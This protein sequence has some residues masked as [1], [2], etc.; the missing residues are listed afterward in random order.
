MFSNTTV[1]E[2]CKCY[3]DECEMRTCNTLLCVEVMSHE[4][5]RDKAAFLIFPLKFF[6][7]IQVVIWHYLHLKC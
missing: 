4:D 5:T 3:V 1:D 7:I 2:C 6:Q